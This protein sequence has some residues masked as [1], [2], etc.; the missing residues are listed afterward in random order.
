MSA[1]EIV[2][3]VVA[4]IVAGAVVLGVGGSGLLG[5]GAAGP[6][7]VRGRLRDRS[8]RDSIDR[9][10]DLTRYAPQGGHQRDPPG[11][12]KPPNEGGLL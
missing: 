2:I 5:G 9:D 4:V 11:M 3:L 1:V 8:E 7:S 10:H 12:R 6:R